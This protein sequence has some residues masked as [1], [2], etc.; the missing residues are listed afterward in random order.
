MGILRISSPD[1]DVTGYADMTVHD[2]EI[3]EG[4]WADKDGNRLERGYRASLESTVYF[5]I[6]TRYVHDG[7]KLHLRL[8][9]YNRITPNED[10]FAGKPVDFDL[11]VHKNEATVELYLPDDGVPI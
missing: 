9:E 6:R 7:A 5:K 3:V 1:P 10:K 8:L 11:I 2:P 4:Y